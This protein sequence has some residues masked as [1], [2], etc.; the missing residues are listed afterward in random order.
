[1]RHDDA[2]AA[3]FRKIWIATTYGKWLRDNAKLAKAIPPAVRRAMLESPQG[4]ALPPD[5]ATR[6]LGNAFESLNKAGRWVTMLDEG[7]D[8]LDLLKSIGEVD[9]PV[10]LVEATGSREAV[11]KTRGEIV[12]SLDGDHIF[13]GVLQPLAAARGEE[14]DEVF[15]PTLKAVIKRY[16]ES[17]VRTQMLAALKKPD[18][19]AK[20]VATIDWQV[21]EDG[22]AGLGDPPPLAVDDDNADD[23]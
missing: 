22:F 5:A 12:E 19:S 16:E 3:D 6:M 18:G 21:I 14:M 15:M 20:S 11:T 1:M 23:A 10:V 9:T 4:G 13:S 7:E 17:E 2:I 8:P